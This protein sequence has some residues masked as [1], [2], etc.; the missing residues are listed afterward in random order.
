M[1]PESGVART[2]AYGSYSNRNERQ[3]SNSSPN[4]DRINLKSVVRPYST[5]NEPLTVSQTT[6]VFN[7]GISLLK[8][9][10]E[11]LLKKKKNLENPYLSNQVKAFEGMR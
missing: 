6:R 5:L 8:A 9:E 2:L 7:R 4:N 11:R 3:S 10:E 1:S